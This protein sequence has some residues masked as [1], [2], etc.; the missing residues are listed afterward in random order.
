MNANRL[1]QG[2]SNLSS[3][4]AGGNPKTEIVCSFCG[5]GRGGDLVL[6]PCGRICYACATQAV[7]MFLVAFREG[8]SFKSDYRRIFSKA[9][10]EYQHREREP[11]PIREAKP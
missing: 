2:L 10:Q 4:K 11:P 7:G 8:L 6:G 9:S 3:G 5:S 1:I